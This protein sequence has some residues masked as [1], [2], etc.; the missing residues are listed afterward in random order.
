LQKF[1][2]AFKDAG[3]EVIA[4]SVDSR[5][6]AM[7]AVSS[8]GLTFPVLYDTDAAA[9]SSW[10]VF[11]LL[12]DGVAAPATFVFDATGALR[13]FRI[14]KDAGDRPHAEE[15]IEVIRS[16]AREGATSLPGT[17]PPGPAPLPVTTQAAATSTPS[18][19][20]TATPKPLVLGPG[21]SDFA[22]PNANG[23]GDVR[24]SSYLGKKNV[25]LVF[26]RAYW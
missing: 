1:Y 13:A 16:F 26:Y 18:P 3:A 15:V 19:A 7:Q 23:G 6:D 2:S 9:A 8:L 12:G 10:G 14:G 22:L 20:A 17:S 24:L 25:V 11:N 5:E 4:V 21:L